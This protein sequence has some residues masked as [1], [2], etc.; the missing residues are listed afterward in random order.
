MKS[1][2]ID[3]NNTKI[4]NPKDNTI[5]KMINLTMGDMSSTVSFKGLNFQEEITTLLQDFYW[6][7]RITVHNTY[8]FL[9]GK[10]TLTGI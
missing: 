9:L 6:D 1:Y 2:G 5:V 10:R 7:M 8:G 4:K 3:L